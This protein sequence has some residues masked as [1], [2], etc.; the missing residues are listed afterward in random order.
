[1]LSTGETILCSGLCHEADGLREE[2]VEKPVF[3]EKG[4][5]CYVCVATGE[6]APYANVIL[7]KGVV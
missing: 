4:R 5:R 3:Y 7:K 1:L 6:Y 2:A